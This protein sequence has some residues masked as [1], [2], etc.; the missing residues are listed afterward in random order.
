MLE[1]TCTTNKLWV[2]SC[3]TERIR[4]PRSIATF[5]EPRLEVTLA[6]EKLAHERLTGGH[7]GVVFDPRATNGL[8]PP[9]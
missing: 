4:E 7:V 2:R 5:P 8:E 1:H 9:V 3:E 6:E